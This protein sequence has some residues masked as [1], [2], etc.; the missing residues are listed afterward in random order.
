[1][2]KLKKGWSLIEVNRD[3]IGSGVEEVRVE[4]FMFS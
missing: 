2:I 1:M 3:T 4:S